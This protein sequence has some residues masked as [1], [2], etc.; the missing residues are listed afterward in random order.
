MRRP[1]V[2]LALVLA[3]L[4]G[5]QAG[6]AGQGLTC[7]SFADQAGAQ[8]TLD[9][10]PS[11]PNGLDADADGVAC[12]DYA[13]QAP[14]PTSTDVSTDDS[15][16]TD[17]NDTSGGSGQT[18]IIPEPAPPAAPAPAPDPGAGTDTGAPA[19]ADSVDTGATAG[20]DTAAAPGGETAAAPEAAPAASAPTSGV[21]SQ[22]VTSSNAVASLPNTGTGPGP[23]QAPGA[24]TAWL[25]AGALALLGAAG[26][27]SLRRA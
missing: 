25:L 20:G 18:V 9:Q 17:V 27:R 16:G 12:E 6:A 13:Y 21:A 8:M 23:S 15:G 10:D 4:L 1:T 22:P 5:L 11:D 19:P 2:A 24:L 3:A 14:P 7:A 26:V